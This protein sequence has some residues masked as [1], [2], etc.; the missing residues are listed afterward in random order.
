MAD[1]SSLAPGAAR[2]IALDWGTSNLRAYALGEDGS[3]LATRSGAIGVMAVSGGAFEAALQSLIADWL[4]DQPGALIAAGMIGSRQGWREAPYLGCPAGLAQAADQ[5]TSVALTG[6]RELHIVPGLQCLGRDGEYDVMRGEETQL[7]GADLE[8]G[9]CCVLPGTHAKWARV[10]EGGRIDSFRT[11]MTGE[12][13]ALLTQHGILGRLM[14]LGESRPAAFEQGVRRG[15]AEHAR[16]THILFAARTA[17]LLGRI[18]PEGLPDFL[19]GLLIGIEI[20]SEAAEGPLPSAVTV[21]GDAG[22]G[23]RYA[24]A[25][26]IAGVQ[27]RVAPADAGTRGLWRV[28]QAAGLIEQ[29]S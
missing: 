19:S 20:G 15:L 5:L 28:A 6:Q 21:V 7:W 4:R 9:A 13:Y 12:L 11:Y 14:V 1:V 26:G 25:L 2:L 18:E 8:P 24:Q 27:A 23:A 22:L 17:G 10:A 16:A 3:V 29:R